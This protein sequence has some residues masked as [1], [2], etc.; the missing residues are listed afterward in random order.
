[1]QFVSTYKSL[2]HTHNCDQ[3]HQL[4][5]KKK[6]KKTTT[7]ESI[8]VYETRLS[9]VYFYSATAIRLGWNGYQHK[10][11]PWRR[12]FS[13]CSFWESNPD[14]SVTSSASPLSHTSSLK[15]PKCRDLTLTPLPPDIL[16]LLVPS[17]IWTLILKL[18]KFLY[19]YYFAP[20]CYVKSPCC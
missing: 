8:W 16:L 20:D 19:L 10:S 1:M 4:K 9:A 13:L 12:K 18:I 2:S 11:Q 15:V 3:L 6:N 7:P 14:L 5:K 17:Y